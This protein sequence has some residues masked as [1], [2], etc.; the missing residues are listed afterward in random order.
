MYL[1][2]S[3][4]TGQDSIFFLSLPTPQSKL[5]SQLPYT[6]LHL[7]TLTPPGMEQTHAFF[8]S[9]PEMYQLAA[10]CQTHPRPCTYSRDQNR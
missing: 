10:T 9:F 8:H 5:N 4:H 3:D 7:N 1:E 2:N 6:A